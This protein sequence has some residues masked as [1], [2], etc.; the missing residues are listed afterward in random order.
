MTTVQVYRSKIGVLTVAKL[1]KLLA[2]FPDN[3][4]VRAYEGEGQGLVIETATGEELA[5]IDSATERDGM[6]DI[7]K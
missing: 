4:H 6:E 2:K 3:A 7:T 1:M 5:W